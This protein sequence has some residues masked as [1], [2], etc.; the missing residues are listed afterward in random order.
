MVRRGWLRSHKRTLALSAGIGSGVLAIYALSFLL[1]RTVTV[2]STLNSCF[3][4]LGVVR[5]TYGTGGAEKA[6]ALAK[7]DARFLHMAARG[8][9][10][11]VAGRAVS[12][13]VRGWPWRIYAPL[14]RLELRLR[15][16]EAVGLTTAEEEELDQRLERLRREP[17]THLPY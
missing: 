17:A 7:G 9:L 1:S 8:M 13:P 3:G 16:C 12:V 10:S 14:E 15:G 4:T 6:Y 5:F 11:D 2:A